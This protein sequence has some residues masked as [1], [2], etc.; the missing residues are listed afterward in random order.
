MSDKLKWAHV[1]ID[2]E[3]LATC[4]AAVVLEIG[5][6]LFD[7]EEKEPE[8]QIG[9]GFSRQVS[10]RAGDQQLREIDPDTWIWWATKM[11]EGHS[12]P[13]MHEGGELRDVLTDLFEWIRKNTV[14]D[15]RVWSW[16]IDFDLAI[17][18]DAARD[19]QMPLPWKYSRQRCARTLCEELAVKR[20]GDVTHDA[21]EDAQQEA[22]AVCA[23]WRKGLI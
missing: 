20:Y 15:L 4:P 6:V 3:T 23:A 10:L 21:V 1:C 18:A 13:G 7:P 5:A 9:P 16:G 22:L 17:L 8:Q 2:L 11:E 19:F 12:M 14:E